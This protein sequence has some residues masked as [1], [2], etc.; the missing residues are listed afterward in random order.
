MILFLG[1]SGVLHPEPCPKDQHFCRLPL[2]ESILRDFPGVEIVLTSA[3]WL[4]YPD[5][6]GALAQM[7]Q[8][9]APHMAGRIA[10]VMPDH[11][12]QPRSEAPDGP[13]RLD[14]LGVFPREEEC[15]TWLRTNRPAGTP[16]LALDGQP[17]LF[18]SGCPNLM[19]T[20]GET[21]FRVGNGWEFCQRLKQLGR[22]ATGQ[23]RQTDDMRQPEQMKQLN[24]LKRT[25][26]LVLSD[27]HVEFAPFVPD[28][29]AV[30]AADV[31]VLAGDIS[32]GVKG[33]A[34]ARQ[35]FA[36]K[37]I[38]YVAGNHEFYRGDWGRLLEQLRAQ[39]QVYGVHFLENDAVTIDGVR[40]LGATL[41]TDFLLFGEDKKP[42]AM[43][44]AARVMNDFQ[45]IK[46]RALP[47]QVNIVGPRGSP[48]KLS[49]AHTLRRHRESLAWLTTQLTAQLPLGA[50]DKTVVVS[51]HFPSARSLAPQWAG[52]LVSA[53]YGS[54]LPDELVQGAA[55]WIHGHAHSSFDYRIG[56]A[57]CAGRVVCNP[58]GYP[59]GRLSPS[60]F[61]N[62]GFD[63][64]L[65]L[66]V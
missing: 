43:R 6:K 1:L 55:L 62:P 56:Q 8:H 14:E 65:T 42:A 51:H 16:W 4:T 23:A 18:S 36:D 17:H 54:N 53:I 40:F 34:W 26:L 37:P 3:W 13:G 58:R 7:R 31:V 9:F 45:L 28:P 60:A 44:E 22:P 27:L 57:D 61:E 63:P 20:S 33:I 19:L 5:Q 35:A 32:N 48:W 11:R 64:G 15:L 38:V 59:L 29:A 39:A 30:E 12:D 50:A 41:W 49:P 10:G 46:A 25:K 21:G 24:Q 2:I 52:H 66:E 47:A